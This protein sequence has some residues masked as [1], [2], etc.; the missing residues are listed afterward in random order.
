MNWY[1]LG[2]KEALNRLDTFENGWSPEK[3]AKLFARH[4][5]NKLVDEEKISRMHILIVTSSVIVAVEADNFLRRRK[6]GNFN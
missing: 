2:A 4:G 6:A 5:P 1:Q 3:S